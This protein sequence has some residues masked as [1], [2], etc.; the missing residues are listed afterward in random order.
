MSN[1]IVPYYLNAG[2]MPQ[3]LIVRMSVFNCAHDVGQLQTLLVNISRTD[4]NIIYR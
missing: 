4:W 1:L 2:M 3:I